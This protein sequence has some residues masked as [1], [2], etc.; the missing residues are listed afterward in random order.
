VSQTIQ[1]FFEEFQ[2]CNADG[3]AEQLARL[4]AP[5]FLMAGAG[6]VQAVRSADLALAIPKRREMLRAI[7]CRP[8]GLV[9]LE[10]TKLDD[11]YSMARMK[12]QWRVE[13]EGAA[14][15]ITLGST[16]ILQ[17]TGEGLQ[18]VLYLNHEDIVSV[19]RQR[20]LLPTG[21]AQ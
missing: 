15:E 14:E 12:W 1:A 8:A 18:I 6:G 17:Q 21:P 3:D 7:G 20:G 13:R 19:L 10:E 2:R 16:V 4:Y 5:V 9:S 11:R